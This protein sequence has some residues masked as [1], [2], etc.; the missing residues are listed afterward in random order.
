MTT[1]CSPIMFEAILVSS[2]YLAA[3]GVGTHLIP[4]SATSRSLFIRQ[5]PNGG[6]RRV[7]PIA[8]V[9]AGVSCLITSW[10]LSPGGGNGSSCPEADLYSDPK[11][12]WRRWV[13]GHSVDRPQFP[14]C[15]ALGSC[16]SCA[17]RYSKSTG[18]VRNSAAPYS[19]ASS[20]SRQSGTAWT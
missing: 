10:P 18:L 19:I 9:P 14:Q 3:P 1:A 4:K 12:D 6:Y 16:R 17:F 11:I 15:G 2:D 8:R 20:V 13:S 7:L 5:R